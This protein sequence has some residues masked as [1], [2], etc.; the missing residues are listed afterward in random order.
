MRLKHGNYW[1]L[2]CKYCAKEFKATS[3][4]GS[5]NLQNAI[6]CLTTQK[7]QGKIKLQMFIERSMIVLTRPIYLFLGMLKNVKI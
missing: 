6:L 3:I 5:S 7:E 1:Q 2:W 4:I